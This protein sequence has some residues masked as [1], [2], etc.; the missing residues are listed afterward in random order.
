MPKR[1][2]A[3]GAEVG[4]LFGS[5]IVTP[6]LVVW[7]TWFDLTVTG[8][9]SG[10]SATVLGSPHGA[11]RRTATDDHGRDYLGTITGSH[12]G[13]GLCTQSLT[14]TP[15]PDPSATSLTMAFPASFDRPRQCDDRSPPEA[16]HAERQIWAAGS[17]HHG[18]EAPGAGHA[19]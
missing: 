9:L 6:S 15:A 12:S 18:E 13:L 2:I 19:L 1:V 7:P 3:I 11:A 5:R 4:D 10:A 8:D 14:F 16:R 17:A